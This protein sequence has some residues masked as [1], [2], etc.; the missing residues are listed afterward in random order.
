MDTE[1]ITRQ[2]AVLFIH[3]PKTAGTSVS[4]LLQTTPGVDIPLAPG[5]RPL[6]WRKRMSK[7]SCALEKQRFF[8]PSYLRSFKF[9]VV[10]NSWDWLWSFYSFIKF[11]NLNPDTGRIFRHTIYPIVKDLSFSEFVEF[12]TIESGLQKLPA[13]RRMA[14]LGYQEFNQYNFVHNLDGEILVDRILRFEHIEDQLQQSLIELGFS[15]PSLPEVNKSEKF[16]KTYRDA[17]SPRTKNLVQNKFAIDI[18]H[19]RFEY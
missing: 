2:P 5:W 6:N 18:E 1:H 16:G 14:S 11:T 9:S 4:R 13:A 10:R 8:G 17:Y 19:F 15:P 3:I 7:H 12:V